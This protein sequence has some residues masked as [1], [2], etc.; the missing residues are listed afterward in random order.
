M[1]KEITH[2]TLAENVLSRF[3]SNTRLYGIL[4][5]YRHIYLAGAVSPDTP[6]YHVL[7]RGKKRSVQIANR[8]HDDPRGAFPC[9]GN[10]LGEAM[11][12]PRLALC[13][14]MVSHIMSDAE[15]HPMVFYYGGPTDKGDEKERYIAETR[16][17][18]I[19]TCIDLYVQKNFFP[20]KQGKLIKI[21]AGLE[22]GVNRYVK[23]LTTFYSAILETGFS[24]VRNALFSHAIFQA[25]FFNQIFDKALSTA[26][27]VMKKDLS[28]SQALIYPRG[29]I[30]SPHLLNK[31][32]AYRQP[33]TGEWKNQTLLGF[34]E[35]AMQKTIYI[36]KK[37]EENIQSSYPA[38][39]FSGWPGPNPCTGITGTKRKDMV[40]FDMKKPLEEIIFH[41]PMRLR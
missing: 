26:K 25:L 38:D 32:L 19:E 1:P 18:F 28:R 35:G 41:Y 27:R 20:P 10:M 30:D 36:F 14:G 3:P 15:F 29:I 4:K 37:I 22:T 40:F 11:D 9:L 8:I 5:R 31:E 16:H 23:D 39:F 24:Q 17:R 7:G 21:F 34:C 6:Y 13:L 33:V 2:L 12:E